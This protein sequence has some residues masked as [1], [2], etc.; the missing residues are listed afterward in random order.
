MKAFEEIDYISHKAYLLFILRLKLQPLCLL[1][2]RV[3]YSQNVISGMQNNG[4]VCTKMGE[5]YKKFTMKSEVSLCVISDEDIVD[6][7]SIK[8]PLYNF[9]TFL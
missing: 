8:T 7:K 3:V 4:V 6:K 9:T 5:K 2:A 1:Y